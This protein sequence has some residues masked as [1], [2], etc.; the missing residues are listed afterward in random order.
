MISKFLK[1]KHWQLFILMFGI[2][3]ILQFITMGSIMF[4]FSN[5]EKPEALIM[6]NALTL[7]PVIMIINSGLLFG[8]FWS[9]A[10]GLQ[11]KVPQSVRM[12]VKKFQYFFF[13]PL[14]YIMLISLLIGFATSGLFIDGNASAS[15]GGGIS[16]ALVVILHFFSMF[17]IIY[18]LYF[19][20]KTIKTVELQREVNFNDFIGEF[21]MLWFYPL[22]IWIIQPKINKIAETESV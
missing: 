19:V 20:A 16:I 9:I 3:L 21:F 2:P 15:I 11:K 8:W 5:S 10:I 13:V 4:S 18:C 14:I 7:F 1:A 22:G 17:C 6:I 12:K